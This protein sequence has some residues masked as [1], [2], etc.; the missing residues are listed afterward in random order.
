MPYFL[1]KSEPHA[2]SIDQFQKD[3]RT[4]WDGIKNP[5]A[6][7][8]LRSM[9]TG[10]RVFVYHSGAHSAVVGLAQVASL[11]REDPKNPKL[12]V[13]ELEYL[14]HLEPPTTLREIKDSGLF[15]EWS[16]VRQS[17]LSTMSAPPDFVAWMRKRYPG[18]DI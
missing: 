12:A 11:P 13:V 4:I 3:V 14:R 16:L 15:E 6:L 10:D 17:R 8:A 9:K 5:Q 7:H 1:A 2:Y 18:T